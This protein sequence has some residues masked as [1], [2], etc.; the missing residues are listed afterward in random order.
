MALCTYNGAPYLEAQLESLLA[1]ARPPDELVVGDDASTDATPELLAAFAQRAPFPVLITVNERRLGVAE[2][3]AATLGRCSGELIATC[4]QDD[5]WLPERLRAAEAAMAERDVLLAFSDAELVGG[6]LRPFG[7][8]LWASLGIGTSDIAAIR[9]G[10]ALAVLLGRRVVT[11][12]TM[13]IRRALLAHSLPI[14]PGWLHDAW[15]ALNAAAWGRLAPIAEP[16]VRYRQHGG[17]AV[18]AA[19]ESFSALAKRAVR[20]GR[21]ERVAQQLE[22]LAALAAHWNARTPRPETALAMLERRRAHLGARLALS[23]NPLRRA[24]GVLRE[25]ASGRYATNANGAWS[26]VQDLVG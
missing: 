13:T 16:L 10:D 17:N 20:P 23:G 24:G 25:L 14:A 4:D 21:R 18:G 22:S 7:R 2:N 12:A 11:G 8:G 5:V 6:D 3:F 1:Q 9:R 26:A 19:D 15:L